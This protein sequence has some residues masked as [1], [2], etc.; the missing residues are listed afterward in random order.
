[1]LGTLMAVIARMGDFDRYELLIRTARISWLSAAIALQAGTYAALS[2]GWYAILSRARTPV[3]YGRLL[4]LALAK[5][6][7]DQALPSAGMGGNVLLV[8]RLMTLGV[9]RGAAMATLLVSLIGFYAIYA[10]MGIA[11]L[12][13]LWVDGRATG[14]LVGLVTAFLL[15]AIAIPALALWVRER[16]RRPLPL[17][18][19]RLTP[20]RDLVRAIADAPA[21]LVADRPLIARV[22]GWNGVV[23]ILDA[24]TFA[25][26]L[27]AIGQPFAPTIAFI[28]LIAASVVVTLGPIPFGLGSF[29]ATA[30]AMLHALEVPIPAAVA[31]TLLQRALTLW[32]PLVPGAILLRQAIRH[33]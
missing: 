33:R 12:A 32:L 19:E 21:T 27:A 2:A 4:P 5:L 9:P 3:R 29:E 8:D 10:L 1:M 26:C 18:I 11:M 22:A 25:S 16:G 30:I 15:V 24:L 13:L 7:A 6:F 17:A 23:F 20:I 14:L 28:A 31:A